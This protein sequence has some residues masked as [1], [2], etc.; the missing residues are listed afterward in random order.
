MF[1]LMAMNHVKKSY[2]PSCWACIGPKLITKL[3][4]KTT[5]TSRVEN[6]P[7]SSPIHFVP[8]KQIMSVHFLKVKETLFPKTPK[9]FEYWRKLFQNSSS[10][11]FFSKETSEI[12][13]S[14]HPQFSAYALL[15]PRYCPVS[16]YSVKSF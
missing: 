10:V 15:G 16:Y 3:A 8:C 2:D 6:I 4:M 5:G 11:H 9:P 14:D 13:V 1:P 7:E 12:A